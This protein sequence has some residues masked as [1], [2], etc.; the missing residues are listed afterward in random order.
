VVVNRRRNCFL[1]CS[2]G[3]RVNGQAGEH[4]SAKASA[5][6]ERGRRKSIY[7]RLATTRRP[8][9]VRHGGNNAFDASRWLEAMPAG[10][11]GARGRGRATAKLN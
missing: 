8:I 5:K 6:R 2:T 4:H 11:G 10:Q 3:G 9:A 1:A 7:G